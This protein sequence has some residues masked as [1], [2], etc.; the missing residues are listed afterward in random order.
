MKMKHNMRARNAA[1][2]L[3]GSILLM[4]SGSSAGDLG[5]VN[6]PPT[7]GGDFSSRP[8]LSGNW[9]GVRDKLGKKGVV[10]DADMFL[11]PEGVVTGGKDTTAKFWGNVD[12]TLNLDMEKMGLWR[13]GFFKFE[14]VSSFGNTLYN[15]VGAIIPTNLSEIYP[16][17]L[18]ANTGLMGATFTQFLSP[19]FGVFM[20]KNNL[21]DFTKTEFYGDYRTQFMNTA[22]NFSMA[23]AMVPLSA[24]GGGILFLPTKDIT[25]AAMALDASGTP[26]NNNISDAFNT[27]T[28]VLSA[29]KVTIRPFGL[30]GHQGVTGVWSDK[31]RLALDQDPSNIANMLLKERYPRLGDPGPV[32]ERILARFFPELL[33]PV[34]P[35]KR[36][37]N[38]WAV[39]YGFDQY[40]WQPDGDPHRGIG[41][42]FNFGATDGNPNPIK[43]T[44]LMGIGGK[45]V[46]PGRLHDS[47]GIGWARSQFSDQFVPL[48][49]ERL[50]LGLGFEDAVEMYYTA[51][52]TP[53]LSVSPNLQVINSGL[54]KALNKSQ[55]LQT[56]DT[57]VEASLRMNIQF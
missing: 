20:G 50:N 55:N 17:V 40:L 30:V 12:Y 38:T 1:P 32:L 36:R 16:G 14:G 19:K 18:K 3:V 23:Y 24:Y 31:S 45:G 37:N 57:T 25:L 41:L 54:N 56:L 29:A 39:T 42:F 27:G 5:P 46:V 11:S 33:V 44:Y 9:G 26:T 47:F 35:A 8:R 34:Q 4:G 7:W 49:R 10:L 22:L 51:S 28:T 6:V 2:L 13:G 52:I 53:W 48:L 21:F 15:D 43:Y